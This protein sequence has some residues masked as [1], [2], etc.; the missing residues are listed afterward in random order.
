MQPIFA[1]DLLWLMQVTYTLH[2]A[3]P[4]NDIKDSVNLTQDIGEIKVLKSVSITL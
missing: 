3:C 4:F 1:V 2:L